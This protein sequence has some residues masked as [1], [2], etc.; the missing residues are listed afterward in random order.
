LIVA[1]TVYEEHAQQL[2]ER[3]DAM[4][5]KYRHLL[6]LESMVNELPSFTYVARCFILQ[7]F[8]FLRCTLKI[9]CSNTS[10]ISQLSM[11]IVE[12]VSVVLCFR[13]VPNV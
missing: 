6:L 5:R 12:P 4:F 1:D 9:C 11:Y 10:A 13:A 2:L 8:S 7:P 3:K